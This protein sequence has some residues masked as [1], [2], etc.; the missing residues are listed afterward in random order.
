MYDCY[1]TNVLTQRS[2]F[3]VLLTANSQHFPCDDVR[4]FVATIPRLRQVFTVS[5]N[6]AVFVHSN[7]VRRVVIFFHQ[8][9]P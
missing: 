7:S 1:F 5:W 6:I 2:C 9:P 8:A 3:E 4:T